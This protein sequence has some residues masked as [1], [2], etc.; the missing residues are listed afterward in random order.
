MVH[1]SFTYS[2]L[3]RDISLHKLLC[4]W[5]RIAQVGIGHLCTQTLIWY[6][7]THAGTGHLRTQALVRYPISHNGVG[8]LTAQA[9]PVH[10]LVI[11]HLM[12]QAFL[13]YL[14]HRRSL[15]INCPRLSHYRSWF[16]TS[17]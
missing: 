3:V 14:W 9:V 15:Y 2:V 12:T 13:M 7:I 5:Y 10:I 11:G 8:H 6:L 16:G 1:I 17:L 4:I